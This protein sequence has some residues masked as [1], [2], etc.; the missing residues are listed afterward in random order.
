MDWVTSY[1]SMTQKACN[2]LLSNSVQENASST[3]TCHSLLARV[4]D[5]SVTQG[6]AYPIRCV[7]YV[8]VSIKIKDPIR[9]VTHSTVLQWN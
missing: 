5:K 2:M 8:S 9:T 1:T 4:R 6:L 3:R 7:A